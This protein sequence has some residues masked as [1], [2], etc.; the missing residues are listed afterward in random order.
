MQYIADSAAICNMTP[1]ADGLTNYRECSQ[2]LGLAN[3]GTTSIAGDD[4]LIVAFH[5]DNVWVHV[6]LHDVAHTPLVRHSLISL[7]SLVLKGHTYAGDKDGVTLKLKGG[8]TVHFSLIGKLCRQYGYR[9]EAKGRVVH[10][11]FVVI[12]PRQAKAPTTTTD[13]NTFH[14]TCG[15]TDEV[16]LKKTA[17]QQRV[18]L[19]RELHGCQGCLM[20]KGLRKSIT[21]STHTRAGTL[22]PSRAPAAT[23]PYFRRGG[24]YSGGGC[25]QGGRVKSA[26]GGWVTWTASPISI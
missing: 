26:E 9:P 11:A 12:S 19:S 15:H 3:G 17:E 18:N 24:V 20:A 21:R 23:A 7:P 6:K 5:S 4:D 2:P 22:C 13:I 8:K 10:T 16:L 14:C 25:E 1:D